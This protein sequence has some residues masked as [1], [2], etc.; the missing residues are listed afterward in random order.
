LGHAT[1]RIERRSRT[2]NAKTASRRR[3]PRRG[4]PFVVSASPHQPD[5]GA[6]ASDYFGAMVESYDS[7]IRRAVPRYDEMIERIM[8]YLPPSAGRVLELGCGTGNL[9]LRLAERFP[10]AAITTVDA[11]PEM[12]QITARRAAAA[13]RDPG[14][15]VTTHTG[16]FEELRFAP[17]SFDLV[18]SCMSLHHV[19]DKGALF[20]DIFSWLAPSG[21]LVVGDELL[22]GSDANQRIHWNKWL[23]FARA[24]GNC[25]A[26]EVR[27]LIDHAERHD[28]YAS[29][30]EHFRLLDQAGFV[31][32]DCVWRNA[33]YCV[34]TAART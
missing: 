3:N 15:R 23:A 8:D 34:F 17:G 25:T 28:H 22:G 13:G 19:I 27:G 6:T 14:S 21:V 4:I 18:A 9:T 5:I 7:L 1:K 10:R 24:P 29:L 20:R 26:E 30:P 31:N 16:R 11:A 2:C 32:A 33:M 12:T